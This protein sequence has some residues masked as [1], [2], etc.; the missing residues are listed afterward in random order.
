MF[1]VFTS[2]CTNIKMKEPLSLI[3]VNQNEELINEGVLISSFVHQKRS[4]RKEEDNRFEE[5]ES[6][7]HY[8]KRFHACMGDIASQS[9]FLACTSFSFFLSFFTFHNLLSSLFS[10]F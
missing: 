3:D 4:Q 9:M 7:V 1:V 10:L 6:M 8:L 2:F 5:R